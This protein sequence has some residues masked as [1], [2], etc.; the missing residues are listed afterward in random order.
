[1]FAAPSASAA[2]QTVTNCNDAGSGSLRQ[3]VANAGSGDTIAFAFSPPCSTVTLDSAIDIDTDLTIDGGAPNAVEVSAQNPTEVF[4][5][6]SG[7]TATISGLTIDDG[8][9][10]ESEDGP[11][12]GIDNYGTLTVTDSTVTQ[13]SGN[14]IYNDGTLTLSDATV[15]DNSTAFPGAGILNDKG[16]TLTVTDSTLS[17]NIAGSGFHGGAIASDDGTLTVN[18]SIISTNQTAMI[19]DGGGI[20]VHGGTATVNDSTLSKN[21]G[22]AISEEG[23][24][25]SVTDTTLSANS[26]G[27]GIDSSGGTLT[28][29]DST[30]WYNSDGSG[31]SDAGATVTV[32]ASTLLGN[33]SDE[34]QAGGLEVTKGS[35]SVAATIVSDSGK[36]VGNCSGKITDLGY[37][38]ADDRTCGFSAANHSLS[39]TKPDLGPLQNNGGPTE[40]LALESSSPANGA[41]NSATLCAIPDQRGVSRP[42]PCDIGAVQLTLPVQAVTSPPAATATSGSHFSFTVT[43]TGSPVPLLSEKGKLPKGLTFHDNKDGTASL[44][45]TPDIKK[46]SVSHLTI[47]A[48]FGKGTSRSTVTQPFTLTVDVG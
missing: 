7:V 43:T 22:G 10:S 30:L 8:D 29:T 1:V 24:T 33:T 14:G 37:N 21:V 40:T 31:I 35:V 16:G 47:K 12:G 19:G 9:G 36:K 3:A 15:S 48:T 27:G 4:D 5:V 23:G 6:A 39:D 28:V 46:T 44:S 25:L 17:G 38:L 20:D 42:T 2:T 13:N 11:A 45:G 41:V 32:T 26:G 34:H 18:G